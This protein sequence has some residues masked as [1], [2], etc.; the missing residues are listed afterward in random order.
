M[1][2]AQSHNSSAQR[3][4]A[5]YID[6]HD[7]PPRER[8]SAYRESGDSMRWIAAVVFAMIALGSAILLYG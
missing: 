7:V 4:N 3:G 5:L 6:A 8:A 2:Y 1:N